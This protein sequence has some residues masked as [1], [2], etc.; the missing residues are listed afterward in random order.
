MWKSDMKNCVLYRLFYYIDYLMYR[1]L[2]SVPYIEIINKFQCI[3]V[4][5]II[6]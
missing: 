4:Y 6:Q 3:L 1:K 2:F 5:Y